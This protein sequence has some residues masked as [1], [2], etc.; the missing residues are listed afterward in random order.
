MRYPKPETVGSLVGLVAVGV[1]MALV[2]LGITPD[3]GNWWSVIG[4]VVLAVMVGISYKIS[5][6]PPATTLLCGLLV[7]LVA[8]YIISN[9]LLPLSK[10]G[11]RLLFIFWLGMVVDA[12]IVILSI[13]WLI[14]HVKRWLR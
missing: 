1:S 5:H 7:L 13:I 8:S 11:S 4:I 3:L 10:D 9:F 12:V 6:R 2:F 14:L